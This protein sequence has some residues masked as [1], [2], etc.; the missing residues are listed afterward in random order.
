M[1]FSGVLAQQSSFLRVVDTLHFGIFFHSNLQ[2]FTSAFH[3][4]LNDSS[5]RC[6]FDGTKFFWR[7]RTNLDVCIVEHGKVGV[8][9]IIF[10][11]PSCDVEAPRV[12]LDQK[13][14][15]SKLDDEDIDSKL[16]FAKR[17]NVPLT[18]KFVASVVDKTI[19]DYLLNR[20]KIDQHVPDEK[21]LEVFIKFSDLDALTGNLK[22]IFRTVPEDFVP[23]RTKHHK[24]LL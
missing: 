7:S 10:Y 9:E 21:V 6:I 5:M 19:A 8:Y 15:R 16:S 12:Y 14:L 1:F 3:K 20:I 24:I 23:Y 22:A 11:E 17:N 2:I 4:M 13:L 18:E